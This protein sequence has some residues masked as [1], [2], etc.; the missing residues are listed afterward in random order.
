MKVKNLLPLL[1]L[2]F[3]LSF[4]IILYLSKILKL[5]PLTYRVSIIIFLLIFFISFFYFF[6]FEP[7]IT[8]R[9][10]QNF[11]FITIEGLRYDSL[12]Y[13]QNTQNFSKEGATF[14]NLYLP[15]PNYEYNLFKVFVQRNESLL[16]F[17][18]ER[19]LRFCLISKK[20]EDLPSL[21]YFREVKYFE[22]ESFYLKILIKWLFVKDLIKIKEI[23]Y[24]DIFDKSLD[25]VKSKSRPF[26]F[27]LHIDLPKFSI[28]E[29]LKINVLKGK[30]SNP[31]PLKEIYFKDLQEL[32][33]SL[34]KFLKNL[35]KE[36]WYEKTNIL[37]FG[38]S[39]YE[40]LEHGKIGP[41]TSLYQE[42]ILVPFIWVG[43]T[44]KRKTIDFP[45]SLLD[46]YPTILKKFNLSENYK[47]F[48]G[49][50]FS[51]AFENIFP[52]E[53]VFILK[54]ENYYKKAKAYI[55]E[56]KKIII[57]EDGKREIYDLQRDPFEKENLY[58]QRDEKI[59]KLMEG[60]K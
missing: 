28:N 9:R 49:M 37:I 56:D 5:P 53:R 22:E 35:K 7:P 46:I 32:D 39:G 23:N 33:L 24:K 34:D 55:K 44:I 12:N 1:N 30:F 21:K 2:T 16:N 54:N 51:P 29:N 20:N 17:F 18:P 14:L 52:F 36:N 25:L 59:I 3:L 10:G 47:K 13:M 41:E 58:C 19:Y 6:P 50:E 4:F 40:I 15:S 48:E 42:S 27:W 57:Y 38:I 45:I 31:Q 43:P 26:F 8:E 60:F 11:I